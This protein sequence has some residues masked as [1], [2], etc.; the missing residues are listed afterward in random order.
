MTHLLCV[1]SGSVFSGFSGSVF[2]G[3]L[4]MPL[5]GYHFL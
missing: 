3:W 1:F 4:P 2:S 5:A